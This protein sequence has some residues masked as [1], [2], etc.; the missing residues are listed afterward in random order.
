MSGSPFVSDGAVKALINCS[1]ERIETISSGMVVTKGEVSA[2][3]SFFDK[4][5]M[6]V[7]SPLKIFSSMEI[8]AATVDVGGTSVAL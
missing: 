4:V 8:V 5:G 7:A 2:G 3:F 6:D 1:S